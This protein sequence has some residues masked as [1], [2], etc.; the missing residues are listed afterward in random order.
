MATTVKE[1]NIKSVLEVV[2]DL[3][4]S[5]LSDDQVTHNLEDVIKLHSGSTPDAELVYS[6]NVALTI[7][8]ATLDLKDITNAEGDTIV[9]EGKTIRAIKVKATSTNA[10][11]LTLTEGASNG[12]ELFGDGWTIALEAGDH[13]LAYLGSNAP[14][15]SD[16]VKTIDLSGTGAQSVDVIIVFG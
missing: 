4:K 3:S 16:T 1:C 2:E 7:G 12:Y 10:N 6:G 5:T 8:A 9:T 13:F 11:A 15:I 14:A